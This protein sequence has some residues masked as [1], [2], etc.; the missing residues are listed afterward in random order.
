MPWIHPTRLHTPPRWPIEINWASHWADK[1]AGL[2]TW[3]PGFGYYEHC[4][5]QFLNT[6]AGFTQSVASEVGPVGESTASNTGWYLATTDNLGLSAWD[7]TTLVIAHDPTLQASLGGSPYFSYGLGGTTGTPRMQWHQSTTAY[8]YRLLH[9][10]N[11]LPNWITLGAPADPRFRL[12]ASSEFSTV[13]RTSWI[14]GAQ[15]GTSA[16]TNSYFTRVNARIGGIASNWTTTPG[17]DSLAGSHCYYMAWYDRAMPAEEVFEMYR[18]PVARWDF[19][20]QT[21]DRSWFLPVAAAAGGLP[22]GMLAHQGVL[23]GQQIN[24]GMIQ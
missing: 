22:P 7:N 3:A 13:L 14:D 12:F 5:G 23:G 15:F 21:N 18:K 24:G 10:A 8:R 17:N 11:W 9:H 6:P 16:G 2:I 20:R 19:L 4:R 1:L